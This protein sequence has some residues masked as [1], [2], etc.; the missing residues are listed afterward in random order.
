MQPAREAA[1]SP[2]PVIL[3]TSDLLADTR[4]GSSGISLAEVRSSEELFA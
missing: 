2:T 3:Q 1:F 4:S